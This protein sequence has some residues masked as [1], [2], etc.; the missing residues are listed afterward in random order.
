LDEF[1]QQF[2]F[3]TSSGKMVT[4]VFHVFKE[5]PDAEHV[6]IQ[7]QELGTERDGQPL[8][9]VRKGMVPVD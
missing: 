7:Q 2:L 9:A 8:I 3:D 1:T 5:T 4:D 6:S